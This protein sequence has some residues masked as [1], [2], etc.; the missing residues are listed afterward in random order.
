MDSFLMEF[1]RFWVLNL[2][3]WLYYTYCHLQCP[4][5]SIYQLTREKSSKVIHLEII[6]RDEKLFRRPL[7]LVKCMSQQPLEKR[8]T[9]CCMRPSVLVNSDLFGNGDVDGICDSLPSISLS[10]RQLC[11]SGL[12]PSRPWQTASMSIS[13]CGK[14]GFALSSAIVNTRIVFLDME[15]SVRACLGSG[16]LT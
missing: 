4:C 7:K 6:L 11:Y 2:E 1:E 15:T 10:C 14:P 3:P 12:H 5:T 8:E 9:R 13:Q 16:G